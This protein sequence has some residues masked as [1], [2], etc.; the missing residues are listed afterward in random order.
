MD[1]YVEIKPRSKLGELN[2]FQDDIKGPPGVYPDKPWIAV[3]QR[4]RDHWDIIDYNENVV[5]SNACVPTPARFDIVYLDVDGKR[6]KKYLRVFPVQ[7]WVLIEPRAREE[8]VI[9]SE[10]SKATSVSGFPPKDALT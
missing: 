10:P 7:S 9:E 5:S 4:D 8:Q 6:D 1:L 2:I 3:D